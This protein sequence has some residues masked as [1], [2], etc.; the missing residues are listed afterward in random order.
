MKQIIIDAIFS[1]IVYVIGNKFFGLQWGMILALSLAT[2]LAIKRIVKKESY[3][4]AL[5][6]MAGVFIAT[7]FAYL[8]GNAANYFLPRVITSVTKFNVLRYRV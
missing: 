2:I 5:G 8:A 1:P 7:G 4:Y 6:G 3:I